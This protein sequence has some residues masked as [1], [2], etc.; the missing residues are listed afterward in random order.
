MLR[1]GNGG[2]GGFFGFLSERGAG[3]LILKVAAVFHGFLLHRIKGNLAFSM[4]VELAVMMMYWN[5]SHTD[6]WTR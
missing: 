1:V 4:D 6:H 3:V 5:R 2:G